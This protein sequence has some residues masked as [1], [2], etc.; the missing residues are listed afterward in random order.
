V[1][2]LVAGLLE[3]SRRLSV[4]MKEFQRQVDSKIRIRALIAGPYGKGY[5]RGK[6]TAAG[7]PP[8]GRATPQTAVR[9]FGG[10]LPAGRIRVG[11][12]GAG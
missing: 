1:F 5:P 4:E 3:D 10:G 12:G 6:K 11:H 7:C 2:V 8:C 9:P